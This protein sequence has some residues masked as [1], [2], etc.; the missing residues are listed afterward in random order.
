MVLLTKLQDDLK[1]ALKGGDSETVG[2]IR[3]LQAAIQNEH[4]AKGKDK[5]LTDEDIMAVLRKEA[6][7]RRESADV[8]AGAGRQDL[9]DKEEK[10][11][12]LIKTYLPPELTDQEIEAI[13]LEVVS[14]GQ[15]EF[16]KVMGPVMAKIAGRAEAGKV[17]EAVKKALG[18]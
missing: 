11:L 15:S 14:G 17:S 10:E 16:G 2:T 3:M 9:A 5:E 4:I 6:K 7:K 13:V 8:F 18:G 12:A 1:T